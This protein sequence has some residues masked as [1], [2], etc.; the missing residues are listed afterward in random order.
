MLSWG[1]PHDPYHTAPDKFKDLYK[2]IDIKIPENVPK[3]I[4]KSTQSITWLLL[5][6]ISTGSMSQ[7]DHEVL[8]EKC[9][10]REHACGR[11]FRP[12]RHVIQPRINTKTL[13][14]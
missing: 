13:S 14:I 6:H 5:S 8:K 9:P 1:P 7:N 12:W 11:N 10:G 2:E 3:S 4:K